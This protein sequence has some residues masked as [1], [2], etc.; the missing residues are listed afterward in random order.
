MKEF[1]ALTRRKDLA[2]FIAIPMVISV[3]FLAP[4]L[5]NPGEMSGR[6]SGFFLAAFIPLFVPLMFSSISIGQEGN[7]I[8]N[9]LSLPVKPA[10]L[11]KGK[12]APS[13]LV[14]AVATFG[15]IVVM[16]LL[17]PLGMTDL[18][19]TIV[20]SAMAIIINSF[21]GLGIG[22]RW[23]DYTIGSRSRYVTMKGFI[24]GFVL[25]GLATLALY[26]PVA[27]HLVTSGGVQG[28]VPLLSLGLLPMLSLSIILG[29]VLIVLSYL[30]CKKGVENL[31][32][33]T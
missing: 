14:S 25:C 10:D 31:L 17:A 16:E 6:A 18:L 9:L 32:T 27:L 2:R 33:N 28:D 5:A 26:A 22:S 19:A 4:I 13:W 20:L 24:V 7:S 23:P 15:V 29:T 21:I 8:I 12:L 11:I 3:S 1:R 30:F